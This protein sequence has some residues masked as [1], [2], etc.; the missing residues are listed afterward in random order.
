VTA[1]HGAQTHGLGLICTQRVENMTGFIVEADEIISLPQKTVSWQTE[2]S[3][4]TPSTSCA[5]N[6][7]IGI[8]G[9]LLKGDTG[10]LG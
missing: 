3:A 2:Y 7:A 9:G 1:A 4:T 6:S 8:H 5:L 10:L